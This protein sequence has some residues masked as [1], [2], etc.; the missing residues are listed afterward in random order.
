MSRDLNNEYSYSKTD[1]YQSEDEVDIRYT[2]RTGAGG[3][4]G[5]A[6][7]HAFVRQRWLLCLPLANGPLL[8]IIVS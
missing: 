8:R 3:L 5:L 7:A 1:L 6:D 4:A 2:V